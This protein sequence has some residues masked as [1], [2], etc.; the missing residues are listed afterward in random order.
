MTPAPKGTSKPRLGTTWDIFRRPRRPLAYQRC[1]DSRSHRC[2]QTRGS[3]TFQPRSRTFRNV[4]NVPHGSPAQLTFESY[5]IHRCQ[6]TGV[7]R[8]VST[9]S[10]DVLPAFRNVAKRPG[11]FGDDSRR[12]PSRSRQPRAK[13][14]RVQPPDRHLV[15]TFTKSSLPLDSLPAES[16]KL[17]AWASR[18]PEI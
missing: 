13:P 9:A 5:V 11:R 7:N 8:D 14:S 4:P 18:I 10:Q 17:Y 2:Q 3:G 16:C 1:R 12:G 6:H 15:A